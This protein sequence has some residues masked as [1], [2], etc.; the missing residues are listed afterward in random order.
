MDADVVG[1]GLDERDRGVL[2]LAARWWIR[3]GAMEQ[4]IINELDMTSVTF[5][6]R[7]N[8]LLDDPAAWRAAPMTVARLRRLRAQAMR[9]GRGR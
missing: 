2:D 1:S 8:R 3:A 9:G 6:A 7:L 5:A 4:A